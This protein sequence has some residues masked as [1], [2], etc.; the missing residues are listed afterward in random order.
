M[1]DY[2]VTRAEHPHYPLGRHSDST[3]LR[4]DRPFIEFLFKLPSLCLPSDCGSCSSA[5][6]GRPNSSPRWEV[7][8]SLSPARRGKDD[9]SRALFV[10]LTYP[11]YTCLHRLQVF[12][13]GQVQC[14]V[15]HGAG[16]LLEGSCS[17]GRFALDALSPV[18]LFSAFNKGNN[19]LLS[20][21]GG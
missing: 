9:D 13:A 20:C 7:S 10:P 5:T 4:P 6:S 12:Y 1:R 16:V 18:R 14:H 21:L 8:P 11:P 2:Y 15:G 19:Y 17:C 3:L